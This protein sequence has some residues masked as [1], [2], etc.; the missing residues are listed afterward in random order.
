MTTTYLLTCSCG[1]KLPVAAPQAGQTVTCPCGEALEV[2]TIR[3]LAQLDR[4][5]ETTPTETPS[6]WGP[7]EG[8][9]FL[10]A[11]IAS[12]AVIASVTLHVKANLVY[13]EFTPTGH[14]LTEEKAEQIRQSFGNMSAANT[15]EYWR[16]LRVQIQRQPTPK[17]DRIA[18]VI[19]YRD[20]QVSMYRRW[21]YITYAIVAL[22][23]ILVVATLLCVSSPRVA[24]N[25]QAIQSG[26]ARQD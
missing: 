23:M 6:R 9:V 5:K 2:P 12:A 24:A 8:L 20:D 18:R 16:V 4:A 17:E 19:A 3:G 1:E 26:P 11:V 25:G 15:W 21:C 14:Q 10:G 13:K 7:R 22:G